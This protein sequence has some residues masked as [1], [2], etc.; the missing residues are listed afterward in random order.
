M[1]PNVAHMIWLG[2]ELP[3]LHEMAVAS[4]ARAGG[5][6]RV[7][8]HCEPQLQAAARIRLSQLPHVELRVIDAPGLL[9]ATGWGQA[10]GALYARL[11]QPAARANLLRLALLYAQGGVYLDMDT[12]TLHDFRPLLG[13][14]A[15]CGEEPVAFP[16]QLYE[17][18]SPG[19]HARALAL[20]ALRDVLRRSAEGPRVFRALAGLYTQAPNNAVLGACAGHPLLERML[21]GALELPPA[22][23]TR[24]Y[25]LGTHLLQRSVRELPRTL[26]VHPQPVFYPLGPELSE[27][28]FRV[29][30]RTSL[31]QLLA[32]ETQLVHWYASVRTRPWVA[33]MDPAF[34]RH[35]R[36]RQLLSDL[37][38]H[39]L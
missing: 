11:G 23:Q 25:A 7:V 5:F 37:L 29:R 12:I 30:P 21:R 8:L 28:W 31:P 26:V 16:A 36:G 33:R 32:P 17:R 10:L 18:R 4:A 24:R 20:H 6:E 35:H 38:V 19:A 34:V 1:I 3:W 2:A 39:Y 9:R 15:F 27:H 14:E 13:A 22:L